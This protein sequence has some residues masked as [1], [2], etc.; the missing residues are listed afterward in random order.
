MPPRTRLGPA[1][2]RSFDRSVHVAARALY[3]LVPGAAPARHGV[4]LLRDIPYRDTGKRAHLLDIYRPARTEGG[5]APR[6]VVLYVHGGAFSMLSKDTHRIMALEFARRGYVVFNINYRLGPKHRYPAPL[7]DAAAA[8]LYAAEH[9]REHGGDPGRIVLAGESAGANLVT[10]LAYIATHP[11]PEPFAR[12]LFERNVRIRAVLP[13]YGLLDLHHIERFVEHPRLSKFVKM[14]LRTAHTSYL[15]PEVAAAARQAEL[16]SPLRLLMDPPSEGSRPLPPFFAAVGTADPLLDD[17]RRLKAALEKRGI[18]CEL[19][20]YP[21][22][23]HGFNAMVWR[24]AAKAKWKA[25]FDFLSRH[26]ID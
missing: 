5:V 1:L 18:L 15:G 20:V 19:A 2:R 14:E 23:I 16:A 17:S 7:E 13:I 6:P 11:R 21:G 10:A 12:A 22:E 24:P 9:A 26:L 8:L 4:E 25:V 3:S